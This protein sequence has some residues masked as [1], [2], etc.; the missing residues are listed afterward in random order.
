MP[1]STRKKKKPNPGAALLGGATTAQGQLGYDPT[2][3]TST[4]AGGQ[5]GYASVTMPGG[6][7]FNATG[8]AI[9]Q[10]SPAFLAGGAAAGTAYNQAFAASQLP[11]PRPQPGD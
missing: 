5:G 9:Q 2:S 10:R 11:K 3:S 8:G 7:T 4:A 1:S 6:M